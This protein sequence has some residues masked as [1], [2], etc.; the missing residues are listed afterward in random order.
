[1]T[2]PLSRSENNVKK[3]THLKCLVLPGIFCTKLFFFFLCD[4]F[5]NQS[6]H[7]KQEK[8]LGILYAVV[9]PKIL[10]IVLN[11]DGLKSY[12]VQIRVG[13]CTLI[14]QRQYML[15]VIYNKLSWFVYYGRLAAVPYSTF[16]SPSLRQ[17][18]SLLLSVL[19]AIKVCLKIIP[20]YL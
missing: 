17:S 11:F 9:R 14:Y 6:K 2:L 18:S 7:W 15:G 10:S 13:H 20:I 16:C 1:M 4:F 19:F 12:T 8:I 3:F 5:N